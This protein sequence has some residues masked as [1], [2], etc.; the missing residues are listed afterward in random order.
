LN[1]L[2]EKTF[3]VSNKQLYEEYVQWYIAIREAEASGKEIPPIPPYIVDAMMKIA[4]R[5]TY[6]HKFINYTFKEDMI[7][8][9]L[10]DCI[11]FATKFKETYFSKT[12][13]QIEKGNPF[14]YITTICFR[15]FFRRIDKEKTQKYIKAKLVAQSPDSDFFDQQSGDDGNEYANQYIEFLREV[16][17]SEDSLPMSIKRN[18]KAKLLEAR[19]PLDEFE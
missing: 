14:S 1:K 19:G 6:N 7:S 5:L 10:Y 16:G 11:R 15:A 3:Y 17:Y 9:A 13:G 4:K 2:D 18:K 12:K 8:D